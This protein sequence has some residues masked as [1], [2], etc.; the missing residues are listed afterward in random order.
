MQFVVF[1]MQILDINNLR[2]FCLSKTGRI[3]LLTVL[4]IIGTLS[5]APYSVWVASVISLAFMM[6]LTG[7][8]GSVKQVFF[9]VLLYFTVYSVCEISW[10]D[11]VMQGFGELPLAVSY[12][13][14]LCLALCYHAL[15]Y[16]VTAAL[17][18]KLS[19]GRKAVFILCFMP[20]GFILSDF[21]ISVFLTGFPWIYPGYGCLTGPLKNF[22][23]FIGVV[24]IDAL[25]YIFSASIALTASR[26]FL[27]LP[28]AA[29][30]LL[31]AIF[32]EGISFVTPQKSVEALLVQG[33]LEQS[34]RNT[35]S[36]AEIAV[37]TYWRLTKDKLKDDLLVIWPESAMPLPLE[38]SDSLVGSLD[39]VLKQNNTTLVT[40]IFSVKNLHTPDLKIYNAM[41]VLGK[42]D[43]VDAYK[44]YNKRAL[45]PF[46]EVVPFADL[47]RPLGSIFAIP[48]SSFTYGDET[49]SPVKAG[50][51][52]YIP[53][54]CFEAVFSSMMRKMDSEDTSGIIMISVDSWFG[55]TRAPLMHLDIARMRSLEL[56][57]PML[58]A[59]NSGIT[60]YIDEKGQIVKSIPSDKEETM[61]VEF[62]P[63]KGQT[64]YSRFG[65]LGVYLIMLILLGAG[66]SGLFIKTDD[67]KTVE[68]IVRP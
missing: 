41:T 12:L 37:S 66:I 7:L 21:Y 45:V 13:A 20:L 53:A 38:L 54:I 11:H 18:F 65:Y 59:T 64:P 51:H 10:L 49:Q 48:N 29:M 35:A 15:P 22:A 25:I 58:R 32:L 33:N 16:A 39:K 34:V 46:G 31:V 6:V 5:Q 55:P 42:R 43:D 24:G 62:V 47:L 23:P 63:V 52:T 40:G 8:S 57:K 30:I 9:Q 67:L 27:F 26:R 28:V 36:K 61:S 56:Q 14:I 50:L 2:K 4:G 17:A 3:L 60:A 1:L 44:T 19:R 68:N